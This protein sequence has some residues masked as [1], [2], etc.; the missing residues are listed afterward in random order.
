MGCITSCLVPWVGH[1]FRTILHKFFLSPSIFLIYPFL[2]LFSFISL[3]S[4]CFCDSA[5]LYCFIINK[6]FFYFFLSLFSLIVHDLLAISL[7][8]FTFTIIIPFSHQCLASPVSF[9]YVWNGLHIG[10]AVVHVIGNNCN[11]KL[12]NG[13]HI[14]VVLSYLSLFF[15]FFTIFQWE[16]CYLVI[17]IKKM[18]IMLTKQRPIKQLGCSFLF[19]LPL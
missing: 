7:F 15:Y 12:W 14:R 16:V 17:I 1:S 8:N 4:W 18:L 5:I 10:V 3:L 11:W 6:W 2:L 13:L 9:F 19:N